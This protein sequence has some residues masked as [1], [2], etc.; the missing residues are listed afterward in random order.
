MQDPL[1]ERI[2]AA[3]CALPAELHAAAE[4][5][6]RWLEKRIDFSSSNLGRL[7][8]DPAADTRARAIGAWLVGVIREESL[9]SL[10]E[11]VV[12]SGPPEEVLWEV[13]KSLCAL[14]R[15]GE[16]FR[17]LLTSAP[18]ARTRRAAAYALGCLREE[19]A[20]E[21]LCKI[22]DLPDPSTAVRGQAA[23]A[24]GYLALESSL[25]CLLRA[26]YDSSPEVR[27]WVAFALGQIGSCEA[28]PVLEYMAENDHAQVDGWWDVAKKSTEALEAIRAR[29]GPNF[30][31]PAEQ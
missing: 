2:E 29:K 5:D 8:S 4:S 21:D 14:G 23:E 7:I 24:L 13:I 27:F 9:A 17:K 19:S 3:L 26:A 20:A 15:G 18:D 28:E 25:P 16:L 11:R 12:R 10:L 22:L 1:R 31:C 6:V 30:K